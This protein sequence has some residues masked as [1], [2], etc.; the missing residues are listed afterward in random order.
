[1]NKNLNRLVHS[2]KSFKDNLGQMEIINEYISNQ[3]QAL[4]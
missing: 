1:M 2:R 4:L 3:V